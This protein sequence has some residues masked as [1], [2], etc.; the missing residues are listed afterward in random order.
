MHLKQ[1][2][3]LQRVN[4]M[5]KNNAEKIDINKEVISLGEDIG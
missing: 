1:V 3:S 5:K 2:H 4:I